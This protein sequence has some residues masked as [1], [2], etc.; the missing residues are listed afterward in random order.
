M[1]PQ[2][3]KER[4]LNELDMRESRQLAQIQLNQLRGAAEEGKHT[5]AWPSSKDSS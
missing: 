5:S 1:L 4:G 2:E 3:L